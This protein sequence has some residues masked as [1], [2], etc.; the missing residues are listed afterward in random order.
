[1]F[2]SGLFETPFRWI[3]K[4]ILGFNYEFDVSGYGSG[5]NTYAYIT[6]FVNIILAITVT[7]FWSI[8]QRNRKEYNKFF[9][10]FLVIL[11]FF[12]IAAMLLYGFVKVFQ[13][14]FQPPSFVKLLQPMGEYSPMGLAWTYMG[15]SKGFGMFAGLM[16]IIG[17]VLL[18]WRRTATLGAFIVIGVMA[19]VAMMNL[20]FDIP[21]KLF[22]IHLVL[23]AGV[24]FIT[25]IKRFT[26]VFIRN[27]ST[28]S[29]NF[30]HPI[31][32][33]NYHKVIRNIKIIV[34]PILLIAGCVLSYLGNLN[35]SDVNHRPKLYGIWETKTFVRNN[36]TVPP[37][38]TDSHRWRYLL[39][40]RKEN[41][42]V[43]TMTDNLVRH[44]FIT[45]TIEK[46][47][48]IYSQYGVKDSLNFNY[49]LKDSE[50]LKLF[51]T[52]ENDSLIISLTKKDLDKF[53][54]KSRGFHWINERPYN[55]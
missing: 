24:I 42:I 28:E 52:L 7:I 48:T 12:I 32:S 4:T 34:L 54:L 36:D 16:E 29:Y 47:I 33:E 43:K 15:Y 9:Y 5:D 31:V 20:M 38:V 37:L 13:I 21:V 35:I 46:R 45:D 44:T 10:W 18:I 55:K 23:M 2:T 22:S 11:R 17:G 40:E 3:G 27:K 30:Y 26:S 50:H 25:D 1:M 39:I 49:T 19:Q 8:F 6:L 53:P 41:A 14:Q 51:G